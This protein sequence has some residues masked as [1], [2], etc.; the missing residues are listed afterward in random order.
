MSK[1]K[2]LF[3]AGPHASGKT[4]ASK[5]LEQK[6]FALVDLGPLIRKAHADSGT[7]KTLGEW[8]KTNEQVHGGDFT[9]RLL[10]DEINQKIDSL[11]A[12]TPLLIVGSR[13]AQNIN[14]IKGGVGEADSH[15]LYIDS[16][17]S[18]LKGRYE[19]REK[20]TLT[21]SEFSDILQ[22][23]RDM[24]LEDIKNIADVFVLNNG[25]EQ[26]FE[27][28]ILDTAKAK[29]LLNERPDLSPEK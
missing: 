11:S 4:H 9:D 26:E 28:N 8:I 20:R 24:G 5:I 29:G 3:I 22:K 19:K 21:D 12:G 18:I 6:G 15:V 17:E 16:N 13:S 1:L 7:D 23:D 10:L 14:F 27:Q 25:S 2:I